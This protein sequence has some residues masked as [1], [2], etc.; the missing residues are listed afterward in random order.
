MYLHS[1]PRMP[2]T[3]WH[4][5]SIFPGVLAARE[6]GCHTWLQDTGSAMALQQNRH[7][8]SLKCRQTGLALRYIFSPMAL[9]Q[10]FPSTVKTLLTFLHPVQHTT[11]HSYCLHRAGHVLHP[12]TIGLSRLRG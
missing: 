9:T 3:G 12:A 7:G 11:V 4:Q 2:Q 5:D 6:A 1:Y 10:D 8:K